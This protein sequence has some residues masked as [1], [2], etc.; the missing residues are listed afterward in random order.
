[1][2]WKG[3]LGMPYDG[4][5]VSGEVTEWKRNMLLSLLMLGEGVREEEEE[6]CMGY[7][8]DYYGANVFP[9]S[10]SCTSLLLPCS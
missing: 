7:L 6:E 5:D 4:Q 8:Q 2:Q 3:I 1:M 9:L 10:H